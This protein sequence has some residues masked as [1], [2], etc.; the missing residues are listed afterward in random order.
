MAYKVIHDSKSEFIMKIGIFGVGYVGLVTGVC[1]AKLG[2]DVV[3]YDLDKDKITSLTS[4]IL[5]IYEEGLC[6]LLNEVQEKGSIHFTPESKEAVKGKDVIFVAVGTP[7]QV[8]GS[9][10]LSY[11]LSVAE[12]I[13]GHLT[14]QCIIAIKSTVPVGTAEKVFDRISVSLPSA[15][16]GVF[17]DV[18]SNP[19]FL[20]E[21]S[22]I[23]Q[24][25]LPDRI[26][27]GAED[28]ISEN[29][30]REVYAP[31]TVK[32]VP[33]IFMKKRSAELTKYAANALLA[34]KISFINEM[35][36][37]AENSG[38]DIEEI[39]QGMRHDLRISPKFLNPGCGFGGSCFP[40]DVSGLIATAKSL[41]VNSYVL[42]AVIKR[43][44]AQQNM[45]LNKVLAFFDGDISGRV[46]ALWGLAF[47]PG[48]DD[49]RCAS[50]RVF[51][52]R[53]WGL[54]AIV[55]AY[56]PLAMENIRDI[57]GD[58]QQ[59]SLCD[60]AEDA[61]DQA[62]VLVVVTEWRE[63]LA[64][65]LTLIKEKLNFSAVF[66]GRNI[67]DA[68]AMA[69]SRISYYSVGQKPRVFSSNDQQVVEAV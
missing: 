52:E 40:K 1:L 58:N 26:I 61:L 51:M 69:E 7:P 3:C 41:G 50:S 62:D 66:D 31:L 48:T 13:G 11:V 15:S 46:I 54:G 30:M 4:G 63:F 35:S 2:H 33:I 38:A 22:A 21:G 36:Q 29:V 49:V 43:N 39:K 5:P 18:I 23:K 44:H 10:D 65:E 6:E 28:S 9:V 8:D 14:S 60:G 55:Q 32:N 68:S 24:C 53:A 16:R 12:T 19:E 25:L 57:Y 47:K 56:D 20:Q 64:V 27:I 67:F 37:I 45:L 59:L 42:D 34:T 17:F